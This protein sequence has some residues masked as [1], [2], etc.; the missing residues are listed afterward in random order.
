MRRLKVLFLQYRRVD[1]TLQDT[2]AAA[3]GD[4]HDLLVF[5][6]TRPIAEQFR[7]V[8]AVLDVGGSVGT[9]EMY[10]AATDARFFPMTASCY[11]RSQGASW[12]CRRIAACGCGRRASIGSSRRRG[13]PVAPAVQSAGCA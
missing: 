12:P 4:R 10:D 1:T 11:A 3:I 2:I 13:L 9:R 8:D 6:E 5:D 7:G